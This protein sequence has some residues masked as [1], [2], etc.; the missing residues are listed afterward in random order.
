MMKPLGQNSHFWSGGADTALNV[1]DLHV[2]TILDPVDSVLSG[3]LKHL[4][5]A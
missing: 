5:D 4:F 1:P 2:Q 3:Q